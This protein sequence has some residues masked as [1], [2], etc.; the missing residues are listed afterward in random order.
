LWK[1]VLAELANILPETQEAESVR[2][3]SL[4]AKQLC[5]QEASSIMFF[6]PL[7]GELD[8]WPLLKTAMAAGKTVALPR[9]DSRSGLYVPCRVADVSTDLAPGRYGIHE[10][11]L[12]CLEFPLNRLDFVLVPGVAFD[13]QGHRL[14]RGRG[15]YDQILSAVHGTTC[16]VAYNEQVVGEVPVGPHDVSLNCLLTPTRW[17]EL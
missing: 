12:G 16:G 8:I 9:F 17:V 5:W 1:R 13:L 7:P 2:A 11:K 15:H 10:P 14:G 4:L 3:R 6:V